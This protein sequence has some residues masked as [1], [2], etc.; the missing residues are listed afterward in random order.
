MLLPGNFKNLAGL[1]KAYRDHLDSL[2]LS[3]V[4][5]DREGLLADWALAVQEF[6]SKD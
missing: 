2:E 3:G 4:E 5:Y 6:N 1:D